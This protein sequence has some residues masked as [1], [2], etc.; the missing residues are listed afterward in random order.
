MIEAAIAAGV[1][2]F[3]H[4]SSVGV[5]SRGPTDRAIDE[6]WPRAGIPSSFYSR[7]KAEA[8]RLLDDLARDV[9]AMRVVR[10]RPGLVFSRRAASGVRRL[11]L[12]RL[13]PRALLAP[14]R[15]PV[16]PRVARLRVQAVHS[17]DVADAYHRALTR[18]VDGAF[19]LAADP[20]LDP[21]AVA[22]AL[23][24]PAVPV[25]AAALRALV[26]ATWRARLQPTPPGW[27]DLALGA[28]VMDCGRARA[29]LG[30]EPRVASTEAL[31]ELLAGMADGAGHPTPPLAPAGT[32]PGAPPD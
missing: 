10:M 17:D 16:V 6:S 20:V 30:W 8:E 26:A 2:A 29:L 25:P 31:R 12:G 11:F 15:I 18:R 9:P 7:H 3:V 28:P 22:G 5:Y 13:A 32:A 23:G 14:G 27:L 4:G 24:A 19:N 21:R 1:G